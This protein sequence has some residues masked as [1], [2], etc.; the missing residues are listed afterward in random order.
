[1]SNRDQDPNP[2]F[3]AVAQSPR[4]VTDEE[5]PV[6]RDSSTQNDIA[7]ID[8]LSRQLPASTLSN[9]AGPISLEGAGVDRRFEQV[10]PKDTR[11]S[12]R[13][14][15]WTVMTSAFAAILIGTWF[16][17]TFWTWQREAS[18]R[19]HSRFAKHPVVLERL[20]PIEGCRFAL[21]ETLSPECPEEEVVAFRVQGE[22]NVGFLYVQTPETDQDSWAGLRV[23][24]DFWPLE[25]D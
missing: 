25:N 20:G 4:T 24:R 14:L 12:A 16:S 17:W 8:E 5:L 9:H 11:R 23:D 2:E 18:E 19:T 6:I 13:W 10:R 1:M 22:R 7:S 3:P 21:F 15:G